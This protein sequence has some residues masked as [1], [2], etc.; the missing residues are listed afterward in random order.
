MADLETGF[1]ALRETNLADVWEEVERRTSERRRPPQP[2][3]RLIAAAMALVVAAAGILVAIE[4]FGARTRPAPRS[5]GATLGVPQGWTKLPVPPDDLHDGAAF[6]WTGSEILAWGGCQGEAPGGCGLTERGY[7]FDLDR[8]SWRPLPPHDAPSSSTAVWTG[9]EAIFFQNEPPE[10]SIN[11]EKLLGHAYDPAAGTWRTLPEAPV[12]ALTGATHLWTGREVIVWGGGAPGRGESAGGA[13]YDPATD[14]WRRIAEAPHGLNLASAVWTGREM[15]VFGSLLNDRN[16]ADTRT[17]VGA[18]YDPETDEWRSLPPSDLS[19]QA[20][21]AVWVGGRMVA[22]D[23]EPRW[24]AYDPSSNT[25]TEA[26]DMP[27]P[28]DECYPDA[29]A[30]GDVGFAFFC[31]R[32]AL[33]DPATGAWERIAGGPLDDEV[34]GRPGLQLWRTASLVTAGD[35]VFLSM[36]GITLTGQDDIPCY[37]CPGSPRSFWAFRP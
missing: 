32:A 31:G 9:R 11:S 5:G 2:W 33:Y 22:Y 15:I 30:T 13:A 36:E 8:R 7:A 14:T 10:G 21:A 12:E 29:V 19:P 16:I 18:A 34:E 28:F 4:V 24:Q 20:T 1:R 6:V 37:G 23:Y 3:A 25:W 27:F 17:S 35:G 26:A